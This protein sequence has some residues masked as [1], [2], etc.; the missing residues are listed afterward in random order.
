MRHQTGAMYYIQYSGGENPCWITRFDFSEAVSVADA[1]RE[2]GIR[3]RILSF[4][5]DGFLTRP[6]FDEWVHLPCVVHYH[7]S[8]NDDGWE[9][10]CNSF[11][12]WV[13]PLEEPFFRPCST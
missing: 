8:D 6:S 13:R 2:I 4:Y 3:C 12:N 11:Y 7:I 10:D 1:F 5:A 9:L